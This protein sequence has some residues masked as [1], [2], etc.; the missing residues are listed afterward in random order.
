MEY[1][2]IRNLCFAAMLSWTALV[3]PATAE[4][5][6]DTASHP[7]EDLKASWKTV[8]SH[9]IGSPDPAPPY[10][11]T[12]VFPKL[13]LSNL[14]EVASEPGS[15]RLLFIDQDGSAKLRRT[16]DDPASGEFETLLDFEK[17]LAYSITFHPQFAENGYIFIGADRPDAD[18]KAGKVCYVTR[19]TIQRKAPFRLD[20]DSARLIIEWESNGHNGAAVAFGSD[21]MLYITSGDGTSDSDKNLT[22]QGLD[23]VLAKVLRIDVDHPDDGRAY[24]IPK[25]NPFIEMDGARGETWAYG[26]RNPWRMTVDP[27]TGHVWVGNNGQD[28][29]EQIYLVERGANYGWS[30]FEGGHIFY[31]NRQLGPT[32]VSK[33]IFDHPHS[34]ARSMTG[35][36]VYYGKKLADLYGAYIYGDYSTGKIWGAKVVGRKVLWHKEL[37]DSTLAIT[38][39]GLDGDG[40]LLIADYRGGKQGGFFTLQAN[41]TPNTSDQFPRMLSETGLFADVAG[42]KVAPGLIP[43]SVNSPLWSDGAYKERYLY[44]PPTTGEGDDKKPA[45]IGMSQRGWNFPDETVLVKSFA[46]PSE[47]GE[48]GRRRWIET[49]LLTKQQGEWVGYSYAWN[50]EQT[51]ATLVAGEGLDRSFEGGSAG[52]KT[53]SLKWRFPSRTECMVCHSRAANYVLGQTTLQMNKDHDYGSVTANQLEVLDYLGVLG[54]NWSGKVKGKVREA[55]KDAGLDEKEAA[56]RLQELTT[57]EE[58]SLPSKLSMHW[59]AAFPRLVNPYDTENDVAL[60]AR[61]YLHANCAQC[62]IGAGGGNAQIDLEFTRPLA[63]MKLLDERPLHHTFDI[64]DARIVAAGAPERSILLHRVSMRGA[65]QMPQLATSRVDQQAVELLREWIR[66]LGDEPVKDL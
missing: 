55:L 64:E 1:L 31:A 9:V 33:P 36:I 26:F 15:Q 61:S 14:I 23:H 49:R 43:Y 6:E 60:R 44:L 66:Q 57:G 50:D 37:A 42:H 11:V 7:L 18:T 59:S 29:W 63:G 41:E 38:A 24:S 19:Y 2:V 39:F 10:R 13:E 8:T 27:K 32:P 52:G 62:H 3:P 5:R 58:R 4:E 46:H 28:L 45:Q 56:D 35:G 65:G 53:E 51:E 21:G 22:G 54:V 40:E 17:G 16:T 20:P 34:E 47:S 48:D 25:D 12:R 30:V